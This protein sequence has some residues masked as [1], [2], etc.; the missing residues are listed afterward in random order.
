MNQIA[1]DVSNR[2]S[3]AEAVKDTSNKPLGEKPTDN[4]ETKLTPVSNST[5][6]LDSTDSSDSSDSEATLGKSQTLDYALLEK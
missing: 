2:Y 4:L 5:D 6:S 1:E 3:I